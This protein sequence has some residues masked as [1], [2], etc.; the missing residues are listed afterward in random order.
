MVLDARDDIGEVG[1]RV[2]AAGFAGRDEGVEAGD[3]HPGLD[4]ADE[5]EVLAAEGHP[6]ERALGGVV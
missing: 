5:E 4:V 6:A 1:E 3:A 2:D